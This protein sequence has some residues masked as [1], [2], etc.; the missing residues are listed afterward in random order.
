MKSHSNRAPG[1]ISARDFGLLI[2]GECVMRTTSLRN[3]F[4]LIELL[5]AIAIIGIL[6]AL[7]LPA[8]QQAREAARRVQCRNNLRQIALALHNYHDRCGAFPP[9]NVAGGNSLQTGWWSWIARV[10]PELD[11]QALYAQLDL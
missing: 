2:K 1:V 7:L 8:V 9:S 3:G 6:I 5:V 10:L 11:Q 4:T